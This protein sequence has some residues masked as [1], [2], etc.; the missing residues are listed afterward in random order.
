MFLFREANQLG[1]IPRDVLFSS[2]QIT[3]TD[4]S[5]ILHIPE[6]FPEDA[7]QFMAMAENPNGKA[8]TK[9]RVTVIGERSLS[10]ASD[11]AR[12]RVLSAVVVLHFFDFRFH[13]SEVLYQVWRIFLSGTM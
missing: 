13:S 2:P 5:S 4:T 12:F 11:F 6:V 7:G 3:T 8:N 1:W 10:L 9:A